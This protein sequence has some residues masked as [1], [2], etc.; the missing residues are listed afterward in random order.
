MKLSPSGI[1]GGG[2]ATS[3]CE[4]QVGAVPSPVPEFSVTIVFP[5]VLL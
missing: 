4:G 5:L 1:F 3:I 2:R